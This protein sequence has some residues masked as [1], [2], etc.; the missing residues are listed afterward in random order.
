MVPVPAALSACVRRPMLG[1]SSYYLTG[2]GHNDT[3]AS[4]VR[5]IT[6][7]HRIRLRD[8]S[9]SASARRHGNNGFP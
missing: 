7:S 8:V 2:S 9:A 5:S 3:K 4:R 6:L 1:V